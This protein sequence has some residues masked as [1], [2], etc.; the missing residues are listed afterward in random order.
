VSDGEETFEI[1][2][3]DE[4]YEF[5]QNGLAMRNTANVSPLPS[6]R[7]L[8][9]VYIH[10]YYSR[11]IPEGVAEASKIFLRDAHVLPKSQV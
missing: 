2:L 3:H 8:S 4:F 7:S 10:T 1:F 5:Y 9:Q 6:D 11:F